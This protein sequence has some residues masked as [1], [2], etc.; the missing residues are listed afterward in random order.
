MPDTVAW[1]E[2][3]VGGGG[4][5]K[6]GEAGSVRGESSRSNL[7]QPRLADPSLRPEGEFKNKSPFGPLSDKEDGGPPCAVRYCGAMG[8]TERRFRG[9]MRLSRASDSHS[10]WLSC[11]RGFFA[12]SGAVPADDSESPLRREGGVRTSGEDD[13]LVTKE[14]EVSRSGLGADFGDDFDGAGT[15]NPARDAIESLRLFA[16]GEAVSSTGSGDIGE[17]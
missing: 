17:D 16:C 4:V 11:R 15:A 12:L 13:G 14:D 9:I 7:L 1:L 10:E 2:A 3:A 8:D 6:G 5:Y